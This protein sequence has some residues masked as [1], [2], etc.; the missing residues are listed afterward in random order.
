[1]KPSRYR[2]EHIMRVMKASCRWQRRHDPQKS[3][4][5]LK[6][7]KNWQY[8]YTIVL[9]QDQLAQIYHYLSV[10]KIPL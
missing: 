10:S 8:D 5:L 6:P 9:N 2:Q 4:Y 1:M 3:I 7:L